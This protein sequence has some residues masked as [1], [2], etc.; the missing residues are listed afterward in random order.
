MLRDHVHDHTAASPAVNPNEPLVRR[1]RHRSR[2]VQLPRMGREQRSEKRVRGAESRRRV[3]TYLLQLAW[4]DGFPVAQGWHRLDTGESI[5]LDG[6]LIARSR[7]AAQTAMREHREALADAVGDV[8]RWWTIVDATLRWCS[9]PRGALDLL[10]HAP[11]QLAQKAR[12]LAARPGLGA[13]A[14]ASGV[15]WATRPKELRAAI[16]WLAELD[17]VIDDVETTLALVRLATHSPNGV[18]AWIALAAIDAPDPKT[19]IEGVATLRNRLNNKQVGTATPGPRSGHHVRAWLASLRR[20]TPEERDRALAL[21]A[22]SDLA[23]VLALWSRWERVNADRLARAA[24][25]AARDFDQKEEAQNLENIKRVLDHLAGSTPRSIVIQDV[26]REIDRLA[27]EAMVGFHAPSVRLLA[28]IAVDEAGTRPR[29]LL[30]AA[31]IAASADNIRPAWLWDTLAAALAAGASPRL[32][33][34]WREILAGN[35]WSYLEDALVEHL[36]QRTEIHRLVR[37]LAALASE[38]PVSQVGA[39]RAAAWLAA[40]LA[41]DITRDVVIALREAK[42]DLEPDVT[43]AIRALSDGTARDVIAQT[44][45]VLKAVEDLEYREIRQLVQLVEHVVSGG[46]AWLVRAAFATQQ[47][48]VLAETAGILPVLPRARWP[49]VV[50]TRRPAQL[51]WIGRYPA[52]LTAALEHLAAVDPDAERTAARRLATDLPD[53]EDLRR[54]IATLRARAPLAAGQ[55]KRLANLEGRLA[56]PRPPSPARLARLANKL[57]H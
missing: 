9:A 37:V 57:E 53:P 14:I 34:P 8:D 21:L 50:T 28:A 38:G 48:K 7:R 1:L 44:P 32:L 36:T 15:A 17:T 10:D 40:G 56:D 35:G 39:K 22:V 30:H 6:Q 41:E 11:R 5:A 49:A 24:A 16:A 23:S 2:S 42:G 25:F 45:L 4:L 26:L 46:A 47:G 3:A 43:R 27:S 33:D 19:A 51:A 55:A 52:A 54:E 12:S 20:H 29:I 18:A 13:A 31:R